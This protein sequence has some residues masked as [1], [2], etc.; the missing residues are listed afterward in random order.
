MIS[1]FGLYEAVL[2]SNELIIH[3]TQL[4]LGGYYFKILYN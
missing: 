4:E 3:T 2:V 1:R